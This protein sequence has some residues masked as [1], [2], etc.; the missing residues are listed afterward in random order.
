MAEFEEQVQ[1]VKQGTVTAV[2]EERAQ[3]L[4]LPRGYSL[5]PP[6]ASPP[7]FSREGIDHFLAAVRK[8][9]ALLAELRVVA[10]AEYAKT[11]REKLTVR[12]T[13][14]K[15]FLKVE[16]VLRP[17]RPRKDLW[18]AAQELEAELRQVLRGL[19]DD[20]AR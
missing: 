3:L 20:V 4:P 10:F 16:V 11:C 15:N 1:A 12:K 6:P 19:G 9:A 13:V 2:T 17:G 7:R 5:G 8:H 18:Q 14:R